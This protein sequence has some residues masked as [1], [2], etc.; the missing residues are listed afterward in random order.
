MKQTI[1]SFITKIKPGTL[2]GFTILYLLV[3]AILVYLVDIQNVGMQGFLDRLYE[4][5]KYRA[6]EPT[7]PLL[8]AHI[9]REGGPTEILQW[10]LLGAA[11][12]I[13]AY[14][15][16]KLSSELANNRKES[17]T[18]AQKFTC[19]LSIGLLFMLLE[20]AGNPRHTLATY[21]P[22]IFEYLGI[23]NFLTGSTGIE[24]V[25]FGVLGLFMLGAAWYFWRHARHLSMARNY[26]ILGYLSYGVATMA[27]ATRNIGNWYIKV[28]SRINEMIGEGAIANN[29]DPNYI[30][31]NFTPTERVGFL[32]M[33]NL[34]EE[35]LELIGATALVAGILA[36]IKYQD[37][38]E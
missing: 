17:L 32:L 8:F 37:F 19:L 16:G 24:L 6:Q 4:V 15:A 3:A 18:D 9:F 27:S 14:H 29:L 33:D 25:Y 38:T 10:I 11:A 35:S 21:F 22:T 13:S 26:L 36:Y 20:D 28:G 1:P 30:R 31:G 23:E 34:F 12:L 7:E 2:M 5:T